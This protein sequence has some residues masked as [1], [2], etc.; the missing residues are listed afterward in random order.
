MPVVGR[1]KYQTDAG[2]IFYVLVDERPAVTGISGAS[3]A[4][5]LT[6]EMTLR[7]TANSKAFGLHPRYALFARTIGSQDEP[8]NNLSYST[9]ASAYKRIP[10]LTP[11]AG[12]ALSEDTTITLDGVV[13]GWVRN[14][15]ERAN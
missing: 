12:N 2:N 3:P 4:G 13:F 10:L 7:V 9:A 15:R 8:S 11:A 6:E 5:A 14:V 1:R